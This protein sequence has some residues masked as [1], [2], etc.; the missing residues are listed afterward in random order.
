MADLLISM[1]EYRENE[2]EHFAW[3]IASALADATGCKVVTK[4]ENWDAR[5]VWAGVVFD[6]ADDLANLQK[7]RDTGRACLYVPHLGAISRGVFLDRTMYAREP[8]LRMRLKMQAATGVMVSSFEQARV[9]QDHFGLCAPWI[10]VPGPVTRKRRERAGQG[11]LAE[12]IG[13]GMT[14]DQEATVQSFAER[15]H[16]SLRVLESEDAC[17]QYL[18]SSGPDG[19]AVLWLSHAFSPLLLMD[20]CSWG[21]PIVAASTGAIDRNPVLAEWL[22]EDSALEP[23]LERM[24]QWDGAARRAQQNEASARDWYRWTS[25]TL[26]A[27]RQLSLSP[28]GL[29]LLPEPSR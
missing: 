17:L 22:T 16:L 21:V 24:L 25:E 26:A 10:V 28:A 5:D 14:A 2:F 6:S 3:T 8:M 9:V 1:P 13:L 12:I 23:A 19:V 18:Q 15:C 4:G 7:L 27:L 29:Y 11:P 20:V